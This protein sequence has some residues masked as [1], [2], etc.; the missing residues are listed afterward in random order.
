MLTHATRN[1]FSKCNIMIKS[2]G[3]RRT[4]HAAPWRKLR[5]RN[6]INRKS[7]LTKLSVKVLLPKVRFL[8]SSLEFLPPQNFQNLIGPTDQHSRLGA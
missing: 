8:R 1:S 2:E 4:E 5:E 7:E 6:Y 3:I